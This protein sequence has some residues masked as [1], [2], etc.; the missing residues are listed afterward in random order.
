[1]RSHFRFLAVALAVAASACGGAGEA[2]FDPGQ[3][4]SESALVRGS[5]EAAV[6]E[7]CS[8]SIVRGLSEQLLEEIQCLEPDALANIAESDHVI[9][10]PEVLPYLQKD[11]AEAFV[12]AAASYGTLKLTSAVRTLPQQY[13]LRRW[14]ARRRCGVRVA[15][16]VGKSHH[17]QGLAVDVL[18]SGGG[19]PTRTMRTKMEARGFDWLGSG[20]PMHFD[21]EGEG[22]DLEGLSIKAFQR[23]WNRNHPDEPL[24]VDGV[25]G[26]RVEGKL[27]VAPADGFPIGARCDE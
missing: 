25:Y 12:E 17:E 9:V 19:N 1:M 3:T 18:T 7:S 20:D 23:L 11:A 21:Y 16:Q 26:R 15:A 4:A 10:E 2:D 14:A 24:E 27:K 8:T 22:V 13:L 5:V 6:G